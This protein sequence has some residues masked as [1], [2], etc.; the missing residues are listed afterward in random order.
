MQIKCRV[1]GRSLILPDRVKNVVKHQTEQELTVRMWFVFLA[2]S[3]E[4][5]GQQVEQE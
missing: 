5:M 3:F 2:S 1:N 4:E